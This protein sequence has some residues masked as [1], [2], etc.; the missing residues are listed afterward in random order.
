LTGS[1]GESSRKGQDALDS[2]EAPADLLALRAVDDQCECLDRHLLGVR[3]RTP[4]ELVELGD[5]LGWR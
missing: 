4:E 2:H 3:V 5:L 1:Y